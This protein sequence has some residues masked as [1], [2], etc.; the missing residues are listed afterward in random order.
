[1]NEIK[2]KVYYEID[3]DLIQS[4]V[5]DNLGRKLTKKELDRLPDAI[6]NS[7][8]FLLEIYDAVLNIA[9]DVM[10]ENYQDLFIIETDSLGKDV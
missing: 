6:I 9:K 3:E 5:E 8:D 4:A 2:S 7:L 1:M 10:N